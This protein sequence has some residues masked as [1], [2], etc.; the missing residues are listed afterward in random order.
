MIIA[1]HWLD[2]D[3]Q[4]RVSISTPN[5]LF[6]YLLPRFLPFALRYFW[7]SSPKDAITERDTVT[8]KVRNEKDK[9]GKYLAAVVN[10]LIYSIIVNGPQDKSSL[11]RVITHTELSDNRMGGTLKMKRYLFTTSCLGK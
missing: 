7:A 5:R 11:S 6:T 9:H 2:T 3:F 4:F 8:G 10:V 1:F